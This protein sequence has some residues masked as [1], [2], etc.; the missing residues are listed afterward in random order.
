MVITLMTLY[1][2][3]AKWRELNKSY[4]SAQKSGCRGGEKGEKSKSKLV[5]LLSK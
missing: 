3:D 2:R 5:K 4:I 1:C